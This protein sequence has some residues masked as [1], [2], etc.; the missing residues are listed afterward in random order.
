VEKRIKNFFIK[1]N[2]RIP[3]NIDFKG[4]RQYIS[5][6]KKWNNF[7]NI[8]SIKDND[9]IL[10]KHFLDSFSLYHFIN[11]GNVV[12]IGS[13]GGFP[14]LS[15]KLVCKSINLWSIEKNRKKISFQ[16]MVKSQLKLENVV[17]FEGMLDKFKTEKAIDFYVFRAV[18][19]IDLVFD[20]V[21][22]NL[23]NSVAVYMSS[24]KEFRYGRNDSFAYS[25]KEYELPYSKQ[26]HKLIKIERKK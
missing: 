14:G 4:I 23:N 5:L 10:E 17:F 21:Y 12:D 26:I 15:F 20:W 11:K 19:K 22:K 1:N 18:D 7:Y 24:N 9:E 13:G 2:I 8:S 3:E 6:Y 25:F 16:K